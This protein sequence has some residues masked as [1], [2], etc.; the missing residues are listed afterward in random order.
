MWLIAL[1]QHLK[2][3]LSAI[4]LT[5]IHETWVKRHNRTSIKIYIYFSKPWNYNYT[6]S[7]CFLYGH[8]RHVWSMWCFTGRSPAGGGGSPP[9]WDYPSTAAPRRPGARPRQVVVEEEEVLPS[10]SENSP[11]EPFSSQK[12]TCT[13]R[14]SHNVY[15]KYT[16]QTENP[17]NTHME[18]SS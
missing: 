6:F 16:I 10:A 13:L 5:F 9:A 11:F 2:H 18:L 14:K 12:I 4:L 8:G 1:A 3:I 15:D 7:T 17:I